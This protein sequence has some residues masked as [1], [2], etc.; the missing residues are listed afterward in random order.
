MCGNLIAA[1]CGVTGYLRMTVL[2]VELRKYLTHD[3]G[4]LS[5]R[6]DAF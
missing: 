3:L 4:G 6:F 5:P 2:T 1:G